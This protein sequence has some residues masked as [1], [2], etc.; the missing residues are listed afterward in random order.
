[1]VVLSA[2]PSGLYDASLVGWRR[3]QKT[4]YTGANV[5]VAKAKR[6]EVLWLNPA[7]V[8]RLGEGPLFEAA[9]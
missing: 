1:M 7:A 5:K 9:A 8:E 3:L 4:A 6:T 2:Y